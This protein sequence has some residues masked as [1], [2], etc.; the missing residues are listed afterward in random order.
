MAEA[1]DVA[2][3]AKRKSFLT[4]G[5]VV[6]VVYSQCELQHKNNTC[7]PQPDANT[8]LLTAGI[9]MLRYA[10]ALLFILPAN[11]C[12]L[13][14]FASVDTFVFNTLCDDIVSSLVICIFSPTCAT[15][16]HSSRPTCVVPSW[17]AFY[18]L[19]IGCFA[20]ASISQM[21]HYCVKTTPCSAVLLPIYGNK[22]TA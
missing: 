18:M 1:N 15:A 22:H 16:V 21:C 11:R 17:L 10:Q 19:R 7:L 6:A 8:S 5:C 12:E 13:R 4:S 3:G 2:A 20:T 14:V 9:V